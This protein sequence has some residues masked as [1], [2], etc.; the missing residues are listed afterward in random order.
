MHHS[1]LIELSISPETSLISIPLELSRFAVSQRR[2]VNK[3]ETNQIIRALD[4][5]LILKHETTS[6]HIQQWNKQKKRLLALCKCTETILRHRLNILATMKL[7]SWY[8]IE[9]K[10]DS[11]RICSWEDIAEVLQID[12]KERL[13]IQ[14]NINDK[15]TIHQWIIATEINDN[16]NRQDFSIVTK[17]K[18]NPELYTAV[19]A[20]VIAAGADHARI[21]DIQYLLSWLRIVYH[22]DFI[23]GS[24]IHELL[25]EIRPD[26][27]RGVKGIANAWN[28]KHKVTISYWKKVLQTNKII[29]VSKLQIESKERVRNANCKVLWLEKKKQTLLCLCDQITILRPWDR[30]PEL[31]IFSAA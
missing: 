21:N 8:K 7:I 1:K 20:A 3:Y 2:L 5:W 28:C 29:D 16:K 12:V 4:T 30:I 14:Y 27:N 6:G 23:T 13:P 19:V 15:Q 26:N 11:I 31:Q 24:D 18:K 17:L 9:R 22:N 25:L 10:R